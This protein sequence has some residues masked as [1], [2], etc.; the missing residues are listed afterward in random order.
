MFKYHKHLDEN[1][2]YDAESMSTTIKVSYMRKNWRYLK[3]Q[4]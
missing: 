4:M 2:Q 1:W 3:F